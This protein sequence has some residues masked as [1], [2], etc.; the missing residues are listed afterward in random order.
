MATF[1]IYAIRWS[2]TLTLL[3]SL[4]RLLLQCETFHR[5]NRS[6]LLAILAVSPLLPLVPLH[7]DEQTTFEH[8]L[9]SIEEPLLNLSTSE[10]VAEDTLAA[11]ESENA[12]SGLWIRYC[13]YIYLIGIAVALAIYLFRLLTL[14]HLL[15]R[16][17]R[18]YHPI[19]P[20]D[21]RLMLHM[22]IK[23]P[24][25]WM[26]WIFIDPIDLKQNAEPVLRHEL[27]HVRMGHSWD[28][29]L[30]DLT[31]CLLW[32]LPFVWMLR[33][34]L[35]DVHEY[36]ADESVLQGG[37]KQEDYERLLVLKAVETQFL[38]IMNTLRR[39]AV[40][41]RF[42]MMYQGHSSRWSRLKLLYLPPVVVVALAMN[43]RTANEPISLHAVTDDSGRIVG[44]SSEGKPSAEQP[45]AFPIGNVFIDNREATREEAVNYK[46]L[47]IVSYEIIHQPDGAGTAKWNYRD[48][49]G[50]LVFH[51]RR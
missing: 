28:L 51:L 30:C 26:H 10:R 25:S 33:Q 22:H 37:V 14:A 4:Y 23:Q 15:R 35:M 42:A 20:T 41:K 24:C 21:V 39:G 43:A 32:C 29:I 27:A 2:V 48:K 36:Q 1:I 45:L 8:V 47:D 3:Y 19:V 18:I 16:C 44:F 38:P 11:Q 6:V 13:A 46:S 50:I 40:K 31:C 34:D 49:Q 7:T 5:L 12:S 17:Q 9:T